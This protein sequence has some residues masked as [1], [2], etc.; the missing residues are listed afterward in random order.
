MLEQAFGSRQALTPVDGAAQ[1]DGAAFVDYSHPV[2][3][4]VV[5]ALT[6]IRNASN[7]EDQVHSLRL[8]QHASLV[9]AMQ[10]RF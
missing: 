8:Q 7:L 6:I 10:T 1:T 2:I 4:N 9:H 3:G 5:N